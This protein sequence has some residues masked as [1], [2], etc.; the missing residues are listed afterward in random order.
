MLFD[1]DNWMAVLPIAADMAMTN[2]NKD[3]DLA[4]LREIADLAQCSSQPGE[5]KWSATACTLEQSNAD[6]PRD[7]GRQRLGIWSTI[8]GIISRND[9]SCGP[10]A[11]Y[12]VLGQQFHGG[13][14]SSRG[15]VVYRPNL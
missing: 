2:F 3:D 8:E 1:R 15:S 5:G 14:L 11:A 12:K 13:F 4:C 6:L 9:E 10:N 7:A